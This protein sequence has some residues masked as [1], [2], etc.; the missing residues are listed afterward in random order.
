MATVRA[1]G[2]RAATSSAA[3]ELVYRLTERLELPFSLTDQEGV[4]IASSGARALGQIDLNALMALREAKPIE[5]ENP[6]P[7]DAELLGRLAQSPVSEQAGFLAPGAGVYVPLRV[8]GLPFGVL[9][10]HGTP[11][12][13]RTSAYS[14]AATAGLGLEFARGASVS[15]RDSIG[16]DLALYSL[17][18]GSPGEIRRARLI[19]KVVGW[20]FDVPRVA[21]IALRSG[22]ATEEFAASHYATIQQ[23]LRLVA[24][25]TPAGILREREIVVLPE[26]APLAP[27]SEPRQ[28]AEELRELL[29]SHGIAVSCGVGHAYPGGQPIS[30]LRRSYREALYA[31]RH[32]GLTAA[33]GGVFD[34]RS[35][36]AAG[37]LSPSASAQLRLAEDIL[38]PLRTSR[39][40]LETVRCFLDA[41]LSLGLAA[42]RSGLHR[43][44]IRNHLD[45]AREL[46][47]LDPRKLENAVQ[48]KLAF[49]L[50]DL[51]AAQPGAIFPA[52]D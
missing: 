38:R 5:I 27:Q 7:G 11:A 19:A 46:T 13:V 15:A 22:G 43:H 36:G 50:T 33:D 51:D 21:I 49:L 16:P 28:L 26:I 32:G 18:R 17:L 35:L 10:A 24:P 44:T 4:V 45:R 34:L 30:Q 14:A 47:G 25:D 8:D 48:L 23:A 40:V 9:I 42:E 3:R 39:S 2:I 29:A 1:I 37:F 20:D 12:V 31:A 52:T 41:D 6:T